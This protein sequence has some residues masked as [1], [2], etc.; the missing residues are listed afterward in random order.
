MLQKLNRTVARTDMH[1]PTNTT[2][3]CFT[4]KR[5]PLRNASGDMSKNY[6]NVKRE[7]KDRS[8]W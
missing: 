8:S 2:Q 6:K 3:L 1:R 5:A 4:L 7:A